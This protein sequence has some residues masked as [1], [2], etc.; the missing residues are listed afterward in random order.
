LARLD[1]L[2]PDDKATTIVSF[3]EQVEGWQEYLKRTHKPDQVVR[4]YA[5]LHRP[6]RS[7]NASAQAKIC[8]TLKG[9]SAT[10]RTPP[11]WARR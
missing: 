11:Y 5:K 8:S 1:R 3:H 6:V 7:W 9:G 10:L 2:P 4:A